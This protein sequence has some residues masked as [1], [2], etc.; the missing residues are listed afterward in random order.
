MAAIGTVVVVNHN[1][2]LISANAGP[3]SKQLPLISSVLSV[4]CTLPVRTDNGPGL[5]SFPSGAFSA[6]GVS[7]QEG[8]TYSASTRN[9]L[10]AEPAGVSTDERSLAVLDST[11][12]GSSS[13]QLRDREGTVL[14]TRPRVRSVVGWAGGSLYFTTSDTNQ[15]MTISA[16]GRSSSAVTTPGFA[17]DAWSV[18]SNDA[19][20][21]LAVDPADKQTHALGVI[22]FDTNSG[23]LAFWSRLRPDSSGS[24][25]G[26]VIGLT[27]HG[28]PIIA[29]LS[30]R[31][32]TTIQIV[33]APGTAVEIYPAGGGADPALRPLHAMRDSNG[34]IWLTTVDGQ[35]YASVGAGLPTLQRVPLL[36]GQHIYAFGGPCN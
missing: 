5:L 24:T 8:R 7:A 2:S 28:T 15:L 13:L 32:R 10:P 11:K 6:A 14:F 17:G 3:S 19:I 18:A 35:L 22:R 9:W 16:D 30:D 1:G 29:D 20:W 12:G 21:G 4:K 26:S 33:T 31:S 25:S 23:T 36:G 34:S 27:S